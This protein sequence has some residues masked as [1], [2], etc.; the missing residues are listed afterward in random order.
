MR[1]KAKEVN[2]GIMYGI[3]PFGLA[4]RLDISQAEAREI[5]ARYFERFPKVHAYINAT[6]DAARRSGFVSSLLGR[7]R[8]LP[9]INS[10]NQNIRGNAERQAIN[11]PI[12]GTAADMIKIAMIRIDEEIRH[13]GL[14]SMMIL[15]V[16]D[17]LVFE[18]PG[19]E[20]ETIRTLVA[21]RM[22]SAL[23]LCVPVEVEVG[24]GATWLEAH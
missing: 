15:Q 3:G 21:D 14:R 22:R 9:D 23:P 24:T 17:E 11:M 16:H 6:L 12:Q 18:V 4:G 2:F 1:R 7:R 8:Y 10:R 13:R 5:I 19:S 20:M